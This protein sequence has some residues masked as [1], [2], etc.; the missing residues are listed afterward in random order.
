ML[1]YALATHEDDAALRAR[2]A[3]DWL[4]GDITVSF[5]REPCFFY[6]SGVQGKQ[7]QVIKCVDSDTNKLIG[8]GSRLVN[9]AFIN[10]KKQ[11]IGYLADLRTHPDYRGGTALVRGYRYLR[12][13]HVADPLPLYYSMILEENRAALQVLTKA[14]CDLPLYRDVGRFLTPA[15]YLDVPRR[16]VSVEG[17]SF[18]RANTQDLQQV[19]DFMA[20]RAPDKQFAPALTVTDM[21]TARLRGLSADDVFLALR[22]DRIVGTIA[23][24]DQTAFRQTCVERYNAGLWMMRPI[25]NALSRFTAF[26]P[27]PPP[28]DMVPYFYLAFINIEGND[29][30]LFRGLLRF[31]YNNR[32]KGRWNYFIAGLHEFDPLSQVLL[33]YRRIDVAGRLFAV[34]YPEDRAMYEQLDSRIPYVEIAM[35]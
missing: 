28:G 8:L 27:L 19:F 13:L 29:P 10:G 21:H 5:R 34:H 17:I 25:Y 26:K 7:A 1:N 18:R 20:A 33:E 31:V 9:D 6:G 24:W 16:S 32:R 14:R 22:G 23:A 3:E 35:I 2:M 15:I 12:K 4:H 11:R 30:L